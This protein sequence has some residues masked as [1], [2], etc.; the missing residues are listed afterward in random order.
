MPNSVSQRLADDLLSSIIAHDLVSLTTAFAEGDEDFNQYVYILD[1]SNEDLLHRTLPESL[2]PLAAQLNSE[3]RNAQLGK[4]IGR[5]VTLSDGTEVKALTFVKS[6]VDVYMAVYA[7]H[8]FAWILFGLVTSLVACL[9]LGHW[10]AND[11]RQLKSASK[12]IAQGQL[13]SRVLPNSHFECAELA[14]LGKNF[15][16]MAEGIEHALLAQQRVTKE[17]SHELR[18][19]IARIAVAVE[20]AKR[21]M[22][23]RGERELNVIEE[24]TESL[25][26]TITNILAMPRDDQESFELPDI[27]DLVPLLKSTLRQNRAA[28]KQKGVRLLTLFKCEEVLLNTRSS[29]LVGVFDNVLRNAIKYTNPNSSVFLSLGLINKGSAVQVVIGDEGPGVEG[30]D[31]NKIFQPFYRG[32]VAAQSNDDGCGLGLAIAHRTVALHQGNITAENRPNGG[33]VVFITLPTA[34]DPSLGEAHANVVTA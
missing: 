32:N 21:Q 13:S 33:L 5:L 31:I 22:Q 16:F 1:P 6:P 30:S 17:V 29:V 7:P 24:A 4:H 20:L 18:A 3:N 14:D 11:L 10:I 26:H 8:L 19:P 9:W 25:Q 23:G 34:A 2:Q 12:K 15:D 27:I 28:A